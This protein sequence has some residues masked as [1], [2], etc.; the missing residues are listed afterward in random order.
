MRASDYTIGNMDALERSTSFMLQQL[1][2]Y[3]DLTAAKQTGYSRE[4]IVDHTN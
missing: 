1:P 3:F 2:D 4:E